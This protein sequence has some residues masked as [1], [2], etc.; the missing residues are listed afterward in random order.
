MGTGYSLKKSHYFYAIA[1]VA[2]LFVGVFSLQQD[3]TGTSFV[4]TIA[5]DIKTFEILPE[6][7]AHNDSYVKRS[8]TYVS[9]W[10]YRY[11]SV[12]CNTG[13]KATGGGAYFHPFYGYTSG[14]WPYYSYV[15]GEGYQ[16]Y[17]WTGYFKNISKYGSYGYVYVICDK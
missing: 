3:S 11:L 12:Y 5:D 9:P 17:A 16:V 6:A 8:Y 10:S 7:E 14:D 13:D 2:G 15:S 4:E 1:I